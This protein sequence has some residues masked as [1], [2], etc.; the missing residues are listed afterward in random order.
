MSRIASTL[1]VLFLAACADGGP[2][3]PSIPT[4]P[5]DNPGTM[6]AA[7]DGAPWAAVSGAVS[8]GAVR[9]GSLLSIVGTTGT[10]AGRWT[11]NLS[12]YGITTIG[13]WP[14]GRDGSVVGAEV[15]LSDAAGTWSTGAPAT[16]G[17]LTV[18]EISA[19]RI[20]GTYTFT[21][22]PVAGTATGTRTVTNG[23]FDVP[24]AAGSGPPG[25]EPVVSSFSA[26]IGDLPFVPDRVE[27]SIYDSR[28]GDV[29]VVRA[30][31][32]ASRFELSM[33]IS[34]G[35]GDYGLNFGNSLWIDGTAPK[36]DDGFWRGLDI[37][38]SVISI[39]SVTPTEVTGR[40]RGTL[41]R[42]GLGGSRPISASFTVGRS[43]N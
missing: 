3:G 25:P 26:V 34:A 41:T 22:K 4:P 7:I 38:G 40:I 13:S 9:T 21:V 1:A 24:Y 12:L 27:G 36:A 16:G 35:I 42:P 29:V 39:L 14:I 37:Q 17:T 5:A 30:Y 43:A 11:I 15:L 19:T 33:N 31:G 10:G 23:T 2:A 18:T 8:G 32:G 20:R 28:F 6:G